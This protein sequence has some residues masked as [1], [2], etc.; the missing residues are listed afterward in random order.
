MSYKPEYP[1]R[2]KRFNLTID[3]ELQ[4]YV[5]GDQVG[6]LA[7]WDILNEAGTKAGV[8]VSVLGWL[9]STETPA[10]DVLF[11][12]RT[13]TV[14]P[15]GDPAAFADYFGRDH[16]LG[17]VEVA[18]TDWTSDANHSFFTKTTTLPSEWYQEGPPGR[19]YG[20]VI[21]RASWTPVD[22]TIAVGVLVD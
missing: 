7:H 21:S 13:G 10:L 4:G 12:N 16:F 20:A 15:D 2:V 1:S 9:N 11:F 6:D 14:S 3:K 17:H 22:L 18:A 19:L 8:T 5:A